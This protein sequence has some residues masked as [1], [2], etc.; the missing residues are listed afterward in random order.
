[1]KNWKI[2]GLSKWRKKHFR[3]FL[4]PCVCVVGGDIGLRAYFIKPQPPGPLSFLLYKCSAY[5]KYIYEYP[6]L[7]FLIFSLFFRFLNRE[8]K[9]KRFSWR[10]VAW[11]LLDD[12]RRRADIRRNRG[13]T[14]RNKNIQPTAESG[15]CKKS[16]VQNTQ[17]DRPIDKQRGRENHN[18][19]T[20]KL[21]RLSLFS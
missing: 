1:M 9:A 13:A 5:V 15:W 20:L 2:E 12:F 4:I 7:H 10:L 3:H 18:N 16:V 14:M 11:F 17:T 6:S 19:W 21:T 8:S